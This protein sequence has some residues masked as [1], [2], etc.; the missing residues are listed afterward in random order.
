MDIQEKLKNQSDS[1]KKRDEEPSS[2]PCEQP[3]KNFE[4]QHIEQGAKLSTEISEQPQETSEQGA[5]QSTEIEISEQP[6]ETS[7]QGA[8]QPTEQGA[9]QLQEI[10]EH[11]KE[12]S[13]QGAKQSPEISE[14]PQETSEQG[15]KQPTQQG[16]EQPKEISEQPKEST[17]QP[18]EMPEG[19]EPI[20]SAYEQ[21]A[22]QTNQEPEKTSGQPTLEITR[23]K[24]RKIN[25]LEQL[26]IASE[27]E[28]FAIAAA[29]KHV[30]TNKKSVRNPKKEK[31]RERIEGESSKKSVGNPKKVKVLNKE[32]VEKKKKIEN[33]RKRETKTDYNYEE[34]MNLDDD[35]DVVLDDEDRLGVRVGHLKFMRF[36]KHLSPPQK[37]LVVQMGFGYILNLNLPQNDQKF[38][39]WLVKSFEEN[40]CT[41]YLPYNKSIEICEEDVE[42]VYGIPRGDKIVKEVEEVA[43]SNDEEEEESLLTRWRKAYCITSGSPKTHLILG[44]YEPE[45]EEEEKEKKIGKKTATKIVP[46]E[47]NMGEANEIF[48]IDFIVLAVNCL[49]KCSQSIHCHYKF[50]HSFR[51]CY[52]IKEF[53]WCKYVLDSLI[54]TSSDWKN[55]TKGF[56]KG[57]LP[58][59]MLF[60]FDRVQR[61]N[62]SPPRTPPLICVWNKDMVYER[63]K[64]ENK[65]YGLGTVLPRILQRPDEHQE[66]VPQKTDKEHFME[67]FI[68][69]AKTL[70]GYLS[71]M[72]EKLNHAKELFPNNRLFKAVE[73]FIQKKLKEPSN[74]EMF[75]TES[76]LNAL[77]EVDRE[78]L[79][80]EAEKPAKGKQKVRDSF[81]P[82]EPWNLRIHGT[83]TPSPQQHEIIGGSRMKNNLDLGKGPSSGVR[84]EFYMFV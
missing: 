23:A 67:E 71:K 77:D 73:E 28:S 46:I 47:K 64:L 40:S 83:P 65:G 61:K 69:L 29:K 60:Y 4:I 37:E 56:Y 12:I 13:E 8:K 76:F 26:A 17:E 50:L 11:P 81:D 66:N 82:N 18:K 41:L 5:K 48:V 20:P 43:E 72:A 36:V 6:Q 7:E 25:T 55:N 16:A 21:G 42:V 84:E 1:P 33:K 70:G 45:E 59:I 78:Y 15:A 30:A 52:E 9:E 38:C 75:G 2:N 74:E 58:L 31:S 34:V 80:R 54:D 68:D 19:N 22:N 63:M 3:Q 53:N 62:I 24:P 49:M 57:P 39:A 27:Q 14:Q 79:K 35:E 32:K 10:S 51:D 44:K